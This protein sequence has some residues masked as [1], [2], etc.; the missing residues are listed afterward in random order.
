MKNKKILK[1]IG[2][3][4]LVYL[5]SAGNYMDT[6]GIYD[7]PK[8]Y[9]LGLIDFSIVTL[10]CMCVPFIWRIAN[11]QK[12]TC[13]KGKKICKWNSI[14]LFIISLILTAST[15]YGVVGG[16][17]AVIY[18][19]INKWLFVEETETIEI[20]EVINDAIKKDKVKKEIKQNSNIKEELK[21][22]KQN[23]NVKKD[24]TKNTNENGR[25]CKY[26]GGKINDEKQCTKCGKQYFRITREFTLY[27]VISILSVAL[28]FFIYLYVNSSSALEYLNDDANTWHDKYKDLKSEYDSLEWRYD[29]LEYQLAQ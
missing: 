17:G 19:Y 12:F 23:N 9:L 15:G 5:T 21:V 2:L 28:V 22:I 10:A 18:Y 7:Y 29:N 27:V 26:C 4:L 25:Y 8:V 20:N 24:N 16:L 6:V 11:G 14:I 3:L 13:E 1:T